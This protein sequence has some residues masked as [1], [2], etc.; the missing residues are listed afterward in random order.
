MPEISALRMRRVAMRASVIIP[1][2]EMNDSVKLTL[3]A[4]SAQTFPNNE[5]EMIFVDNSPV[6]N[7]EFFA[8]QDHLVLLHE[9]KPGQFAARNLGCSKARGNV[10]LFT[11]AD[12]IPDKYWVERM[13]Q[14]VEAGADRVGG[15]I[16]LITR[17]TTPG[18][19]ERFELA[20]TFDQARSINYR[21]HVATANMG[22]SKKILSVVGS[23]NETCLSGGDLEWS[24]RFNRLGF[25][26]TLVD[27]AVVYHPT[28]GTLRALMRHRIRLAGNVICQEGPKNRLLWILKLASFR[29]GVAQKLWADKSVSLL[30][31]VAISAIGI[32]LHVWMSGWSVLFSFGVPPPRK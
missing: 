31:Y 13:V 9:P 22:I 24:M 20:T 18:V 32:F 10:L 4:L 8:R 2:F 19:V 28:R 7:P 21:G 3:E 12:C 25:S 23:F 27:S 30:D 17:S 14:A 15:V 16:K 1:F 11:D 29:R 5:F 26:T 6:P